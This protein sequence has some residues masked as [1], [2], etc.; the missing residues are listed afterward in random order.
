LEPALVGRVRYQLEGLRDAVRRLPKHQIW[1]HNVAGDLPGNGD[2][3][4]VQM[5][6]ELVEANRGKRGFTY[7]HRHLSSEDLQAIRAAN[8][9][10]FTINLSANTLDEA[11]ALA[12]KKAGRSP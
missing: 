2:K 3:I 6:T 12:R 1:R 11:D 9:S 8:R 5:L 7:T 4:N 10:G